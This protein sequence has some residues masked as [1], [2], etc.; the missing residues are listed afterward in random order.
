MKNTKIGAVDDTHFEVLGIY[1]RNLKWSVEI[2]LGKTEVSQL[3]FR[4]VIAAQ[5]SAD[6]S[7]K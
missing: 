4:N 1:K 5:K 3:F 2:D 7:G 6:S